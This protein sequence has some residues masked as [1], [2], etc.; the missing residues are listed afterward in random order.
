MP[1]FK[2]PS[3]VTLFP[4]MVLSN[5]SDLD[6]TLNTSKILG[7]SP[8]IFTISFNITWLLSWHATLFVLNNRVSKSI[9]D[10]MLYA[11]DITSMFFLLLA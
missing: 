8:F 1:V 10:L 9:F 6:N 5:K 11:S 2:L 3:I 7:L 4:E